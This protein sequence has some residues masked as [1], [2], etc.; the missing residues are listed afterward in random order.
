[1]PILPLV[2][3]TD[4]CGQITASRLMRLQM[5]VRWRR[6]VVLL[7]PIGTD[8][9]VVKVWITRFADKA[10]GAGTLVSPPLA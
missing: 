1:M 2:E 6:T 3:V 5:S 7:T 4:E 8:H 10:M 9:R